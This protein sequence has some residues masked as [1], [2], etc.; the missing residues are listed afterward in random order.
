MS[1]AL[2]E[3]ATTNYQLQSSIEVM[4]PVDYT[5]QLFSQNALFLL[6]ISY[7]CHR[8]YWGMQGPVDLPVPNGFAFMLVA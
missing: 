3:S 8:V 2:C 6:Q 5:Y 7:Q 4:E 1:I